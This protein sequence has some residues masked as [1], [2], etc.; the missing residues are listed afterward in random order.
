MRTLD[1]KEEIIRI[2][3]KGFSPHIERLYVFFNEGK[4]VNEEQ[5]KPLAGKERE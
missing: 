5:E 1:V 3:S 4:V 2:N